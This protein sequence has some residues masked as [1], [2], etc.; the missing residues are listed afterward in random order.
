MLTCRMGGKRGGGGCGGGRGWARQCSP[1]GKCM[2]T[3]SLALSE[4]LSV[5]WSV[6]LE[7]SAVILAM[8]LV[9]RSVSASCD[10]ALEVS[11][12]EAGCLLCR[13]ASA[14][15]CSCCLSTCLPASAPAPCHTSYQ[16]MPCHDSSVSIV[17]GRIRFIPA[18][19]IL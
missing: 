16:C 5:A 11:V 13:L 12:V 10:V 18:L 14:A 9:R 6:G 3:S 15:S 1:K 17:T 8:S 19:P 4:T 2:L 7:V